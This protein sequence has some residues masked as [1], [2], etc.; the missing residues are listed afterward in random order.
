M[1]LVFSDERTEMR[2]GSS[3]VLSVLGVMFLG[4]SLSSP[5]FAQEYRIGPGDLLAVTVWG[6]SDLS[7]EFP[8]D[9]D[10]YL[11]FPL[12]GRVKADGL[13]VGELAARL[14]DLLGRDYLVD[15]QVMVS[16]NEFR[17]KKVRVVGEAERPGVYYLTGQSTLLEILSQAGGF[18]KEASK[19]VILYRQRRGSAAGPSR[20]RMILHL[21]LERLQAGDSTENVRLEDGD[22]IH[23]PRGQKFFVLGQ[24]KSAGTFPLDKETTM[25]EAITLAGGLTDEAAPSGLKVIRRGAGGKQETISLDLSGAF[26]KDGEFKIRDADIVLVPKGNTFFV[27][28]EVKKPGAYLLD[29]QTT[30][31]EGVTI[32]GGF[33]DKASPSWTYLLR[34]TPE[35]RQV[36]EVDLGDVMEAQ[37]KDVTL[38]ENDIVIVPESFF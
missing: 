6:H 25:F 28:G 33:T 18:S 17:S 26:P 2:R 9:T 1:R 4:L 22:T 19:Q 20:G 29:K 14:R 36:I 24:V 7:G 8:V 38:R 30:V 35:D 37:G 15:P 34:D 10:G 16:V 31:L 13:T 11:P 23:I 32:A 21:D 12:V 3:R 27:L 5:A